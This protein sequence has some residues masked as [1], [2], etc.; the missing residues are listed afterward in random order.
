ME[1]WG[2]KRT[3]GSRTAVLSFGSCKSL[4][5]LHLYNDGGELTHCVSGTSYHSWCVV[6]VTKNSEIIQCFAANTPCVFK[7]TSSG[8]TGAMQVT[9]PGFSPWKWPS[10]RSWSSALSGSSAG[11][12]EQS[13]CP[14]P[15]SPPWEARVLNAEL[16]GHKVDV[17]TATVNCHTWIKSFLHT[18]CHSY[19]AL[20]LIVCEDSHSSWSW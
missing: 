17:L 10:N 8:R 6:T 4:V 12:P 11:L 2:W 18:N 1:V 19:S 13:T 5:R 20:R 14:C 15:A 16:P 3:E 7:I 9:D